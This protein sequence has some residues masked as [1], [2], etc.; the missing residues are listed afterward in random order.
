MKLPLRIGLVVIELL[1]LFSQAVRAQPP[2]SGTIF[3]DPDIITA[4]DPTTFVDV[5]SA[6][7]GF[8]WMYD[9]RVN[10]WTYVNAYLFNASFDDGLIAEIQIN[11]EFGSSAAALTE[12]QK[13]GPV[14]GRLP[15][16]LRADVETVWIHQGTEPFGGGNN[17]LLIHTGQA[18]VYEMDG[19]LEETLVHEA[20]HTSLD[21]NHA[22]APGWLAAQASDGEFISTYAQDYPTREDVAESFLTYLAIRY[23][24]DRISQSL[25]DTIM[26]TIPNRIDYFD[27]QSFDM[28]P[29]I[30]GLPGDYNHDSRVDA[31]DYVVWRKT[32]GTQPK[33]DQWRSKFGATIGSG[34][35]SNAPIPE[36]ASELLPL[37]SIAVAV[38]IR[39]RL[40]VSRVPSTR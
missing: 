36:P 16:A 30:T 32:D 14:I 29:F 31:A 39:R 27:A 21:A 15:T 40:V 24:S 1:A 35:M 13:Y 33:Y 22:S 3:I 17:N 20:S 9:R 4:S 6:G 26:H 2:F 11:P 23:R 18:D 8:R 5:A 38:W 12:A 19:I 37:T 25:T 10:N 28:Y 7:Q 34:S